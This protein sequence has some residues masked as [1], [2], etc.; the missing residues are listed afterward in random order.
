MDKKIIYFHAHGKFISV[1]FFAILQDRNSMCNIYEG[2]NV[3]NHWSKYI[4]FHLLRQSLRLKEMHTT[5]LTGKS[6]S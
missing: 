6:S 2:K 1:N 5:M 4:A 3:E